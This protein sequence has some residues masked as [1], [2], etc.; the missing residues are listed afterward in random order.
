MNTINGR[1]LEEKVLFPEDIFRAGSVIK[2]LYIDSS[3]TLHTACQSR[4]AAGYVPMS[5]KDLTDIVNTY[6]PTSLAMARDIW[7]TL[8][9]CEHARRVN[10]ERQTCAGSIKS[11]VGF[12]VSVLGTTDLR[13][14]SSS[15]DVP[16]EG[17]TS[18]SS[19]SQR[20]EVVAVR[21]VTAAGARTASTMTC[22]SMEFPGPGYYCHAI[23]PTKAYE[24]VLLRKEEGGVPA[25]TTMR[26]LAVCHLDTSG[27]DPHMSFF[28]DR[29]IKPGDATACHFLSRGSVLWVPTAWTQQRA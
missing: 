22:H 8:N 9:L 21:P 12:A 3:A 10:G 17:V 2:N 28:V 18:S 1:P 23:N 29:G 24:V 5:R 6:A 26:A 11:M 4:A 15:R 20:Y 16:A 25:T 27:F 14:F 19:S 13:A 7:S